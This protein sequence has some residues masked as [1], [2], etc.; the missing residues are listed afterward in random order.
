M[1]IPQSGI[2]KIT[3]PTGKMYIG[4]TVNLNRRKNEY[5]KLYCKKQ[6]K[7][8]YSIKKHGWENHI[9]EVIEECL[10]EQLDEREIFYKQHFINEFGW[11]KILFCHL[12]DGK[13]GYKSE[14]TKQKMSESNKGISRPRSEETKQKHKQTIKEKG[15]WGHKL[16]G[17]GTPRTKL[18]KS[19]VQILL[20]NTIIKQ[21]SSISEAELFYSGDKDKDNI[22]ACCRGRQ[23]TAYGFIWEYKVIED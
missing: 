7:L 8:Y 5:N 2:Y 21:W 17:K 11:S 3:S 15:F 18:R 9:F 1:N 16:G 4:S 6:P 22:A 20:D 23:K 10:I 14:E 12:I 13:G 19:I